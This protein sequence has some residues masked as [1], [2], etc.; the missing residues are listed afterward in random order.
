M[1]LRR[2]EKGGEGLFRIERRGKEPEKA[3]LLPPFSLYPCCPLPRYGDPSEKSACSYSPPPLPL[4]SQP[5]LYSAP[6][7]EEELGN[8]SRALLL[9]CPPKVQGGAVGSEVQK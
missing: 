6:K 3:T 7:E 8:F 2:E 9:S 5:T 4:L 1:K